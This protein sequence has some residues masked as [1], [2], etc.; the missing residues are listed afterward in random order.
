[1]E[2][3]IPH[4]FSSN[5]IKV[6]KE[7]LN[8]EVDITHSI[9]KGIEIEHS[10]AISDV[11]Y[12]LISIIDNGIGFDPQEGE[13]NLLCFI[14]FM[15]KGNRKEGSDLPSAKRSWTCMEVLLLRNAH[16]SVPNLNVTF[17]LRSVV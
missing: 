15:K 4:Y 12:N 11:T 5:A 17:R 16:L 9:K 13:K 14:A 7:E 8:P 1:M 2:N 6:R 10:A 3:R